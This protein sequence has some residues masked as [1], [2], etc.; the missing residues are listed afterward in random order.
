[1]AGWY[2]DDDQRQGLSAG[3]HANH[4]ASGRVDDG[5]GDL[6]VA[7]D[8]E[9]PADEVADQQAVPQEVAGT[10]HCVAVELGRDL[11]RTEQVGSLTGSWPAARLAAGRVGKRTDRQVNVVPE[12]PV[13]VSDVS[14]AQGA[15]W[16]VNGR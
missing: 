14:S 15:R 11:I 3:E 7:R 5:R 8:L 13:E 6:A 12:L 2:R 1:M 16:I 10:D 4:L 9:F